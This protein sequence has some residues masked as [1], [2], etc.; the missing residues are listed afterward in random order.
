VNGNRVSGL[1]LNLWQVMGAAWILQ[2]EQGLIG[3]GVVA[4]DCG[5]GKTVSAL[6]AIKV[7]ADRAKAKAASGEKVTFRPTLIL[8]PSIVVDV[9]FTECQQFFPDLLMYRYFE[10]KTKVSNLTLR[11]RVLPSNPDHLRRWLETECPSDDPATGYKIV[12]SSYST[13]W[14]RTL[15]QQTTAGSGKPPSVVA[16]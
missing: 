7:D 5:V 11:E 14:Q 9:W 6:T 12:V 3:G 10:T 13:W 8:A 2:Q 16:R 15:K 1:L 4:D